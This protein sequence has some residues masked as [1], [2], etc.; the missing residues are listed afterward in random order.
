MKR[1][2]LILLVFVMIMGNYLY[3]GTTAK[4]LGKSSDYWIIDK[5]KDWGVKVGMYGYFMTWVTAGGKKYPM[6]AAKY[7]VKSV[8]SK[9]SYVKII[10][11]GDGFSEKDFKWAEFIAELERVELK[12]ILKK[13]TPK[14]KVKRE[15][16][17]SGKS[18]EWYLEQG[19][20]EFDRGNYKR[21]KKYYKRVLSIDNEDIAASKGIKECDKKISE[22]RKQKQEELKLR[23]ILKKKKSFMNRGNYYRSKGKLDIAIEYYV[24]AYNVI[25]ERSEDVLNIFYKISDKDYKEINNVIEKT[26]FMNIYEKSDLLYKLSKLLYEKN[27]LKIGL[28]IINKSIEINY[29]EKSVILRDKI[30][31]EMELLNTCYIDVSCYPYGDLY[32]NDKLI[33]EIPPRR[34]IKLEPGK[35]EIM[36]KNSKDIYKEEIELKGGEIR[37]IHKNFKKGGE[38]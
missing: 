26:D 34:R 15:K 37:R 28:N 5:G 12:K 4:I 13:S 32:I 22:I 8:K 7:V 21:A 35:Y 27:K 18:I 6:R 38:K 17:P 30:K 2:V 3:S 31:K 24:K 36:I 29:N 23:N 9:K 14:P 10:K 1:F 25:P 20:N 11:Y 19:D 33:G 16:I